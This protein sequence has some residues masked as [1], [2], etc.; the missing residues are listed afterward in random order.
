MMLYIF[1][2]VLIFALF[3]LQYFSK[4]NKSNEIN[5]CF[6]FFIFVFIA[7]LSGTRY[8]I[9]VDYV[10][11]E[12]IFYN[13]NGYYDRI[14][15]DI[16]N[17]YGLE[18]GY[19][20]IN[21]FF[22]FSEDGFYILIFFIAIVTMY[23]MHLAIKKLPI[24][25]QYLAYFIL[26]TH[27]FVFLMQ[28]QIRQAASIAIFIYS[29]KYIN[30]SDKIKYFGLNLLS[31]ITFHYSALVV[32]P[33]YLVKF[34]NL[35]RVR[36]LVAICVVVPASLFGV[37]NYILYEIVKSISIYDAYLSTSF[38]E[39]SQLSVI[40]LITVLYF[41]LIIYFFDKGNNE[42]KIFFIGL[43]LSCVFSNFSLLERLSGYFIYVKIISIPL[44]FFEVEKSSNRYLL[45]L[46]LIIYSI[47]MY[48]NAISI[49]SGGNIPYVNILEK[50]I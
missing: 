23:I 46:S 39:V 38:S 41:F 16:N 32:L 24:K 50:I 2:P 25:Y 49:N 7:V 15:L 22:G 35:T 19:I 42:N 47:A 36:M 28:N 40:N 30:S 21:K 4:T 29:L 44:L 8:G 33:F 20:L 14:T 11:Y 3:S 26:V 34:V 48:I 43:I 12:N 37:F 13:L 9:G 17:I 1:Y 18:P 31:A 5:I 6:M 10:N 45:F 27:A